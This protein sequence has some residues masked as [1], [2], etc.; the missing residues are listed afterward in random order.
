MDEEATKAIK[1]RWSRELMRRPEVVGVGIEEDA[2][3]RPVLVVHLQAELPPPGLP[4]TLDGLPVR[5]ERTGPI[6]AG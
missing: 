2:D 3:G 4:P 1:R 5:V 6:R